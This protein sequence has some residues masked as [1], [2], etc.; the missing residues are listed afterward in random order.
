MST[1]TEKTKANIRNTYV[2]LLDTHGPTDIS[3]TDICNMANINRSTFYEYYPYID[4]LIEDVIY[5]QINSISD[6]NDVLYDAYYLEHETTPENVREYI[7]NFVNNAV[8]SKLLRSNEANLFKAS[9]VNAQ[10]EYE[11][12]RYGIADEESKMKINYRASGVLA[13]IFIWL[14]KGYDFSLGDLADYLYEE[15]RKSEGQGQ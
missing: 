7:E 14:E 13:T 12:N 9:I 1:K 2:K 10:C 11:I 5:E 8:F 3:V 6:V 15:I 4:K